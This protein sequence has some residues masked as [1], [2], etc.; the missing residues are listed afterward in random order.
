MRY[1]PVACNYILFGG[2][3]TNLWLSAEKPD[4]EMLTSGAG[5]PDSL[6]ISINR[7]TTFPNYTLDDSRL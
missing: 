3:R 1:C 2:R 7:Y 4:F 6:D 5:T